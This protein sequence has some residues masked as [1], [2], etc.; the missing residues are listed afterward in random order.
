MI[1]NADDQL[2]LCDSYSRARELV[3][4]MTLTRSPR[5]RI[6][7][8]L[9]WGN[10]CDAPWAY[11]NSFAKLLRESLKQVD[12]SDVLLAP[13][14]AWFSALD[15]LFKVYR[16]C[17]KGRELG[18]SWTTDLDVAKK[19]AIGMRCRN[20]NPTLVTAY[21]PKE[22]VFAVHLDRGESEVA[23]DPRRLKRLR[24]YSDSDT[25]LE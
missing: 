5:E 7:L 14:R 2:A 9:E 1:A 21:I 13:E 17:E 4:A 12:L 18:L 25:A 19:F 15:P 3:T 6:L 24:K 16:G 8:F 11:R 22:H 23:I 20:Q 10:V